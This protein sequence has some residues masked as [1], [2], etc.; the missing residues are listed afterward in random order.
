MERGTVVRQVTRTHKPSDAVRLVRNGLA[1][2]AMPDLNDLQ[3]EIGQDLYPYVQ[4]VHNAPAINGWTFNP[5]ALVRAVNGLL[6]LGKERALDVLRKYFAVATANSDRREQLDLDEQRIFLVLRLLFIC[7]QGEHCLPPL[8]IGAPDVEPPP[9]DDTWPL[10]PLAVVDDIPF[11][12]TSGFGFMFGGAAQSSVEHIDYYAK[13]CELRDHPLEPKTSPLVA[14]ESLV[15]SGGWQKMV[16]AE[17]EGHRA[18]LSR[19]ALRTLLALNASEVDHL[20]ASSNEDLLTEWPKQIGE[21]AK[22]QPNWG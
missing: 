2:K 20:L 8:L 15:A 12:L 3:T 1:K 5:A 7:G 22:L 11:L 4:L 17:A 6:P 16:S 18:M 14:V 21:L 10:F 9:G 19:Q 13:Y